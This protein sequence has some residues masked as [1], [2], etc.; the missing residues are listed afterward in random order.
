MK[1]ECVSTASPDHDLILKIRWLAVKHGTPE[2]NMDETKQ[3]DKER[4]IGTEGT[5]D[6]VPPCLYP[7][8]VV[9]A[10]GS[11]SSI[12]VS[13]DLRRPPASGGYWA[14]SECSLLKDVSSYQIPVR[15]SRKDN[16]KKRIWS[17]LS[18]LIFSCVKKSRMDTMRRQSETSMR[19]VC[20]APRSGN[21]SVRSVHP[22][23]QRLR[24]RHEDMYTIF[25]EDLFY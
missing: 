10:H 20:V 25:N 21:V 9:I 18:S 16:L 1:G 6:R 2:D 15:S 5:D 23:I 22:A 11:V 8:V 4:E 17:A 13:S 19:S 3:Y 24:K 14:C 7:E 12:S